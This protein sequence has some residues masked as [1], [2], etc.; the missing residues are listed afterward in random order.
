MII[1]RNSIMYAT[2]CKLRHPDLE[3]VAPTA[4][5]ATGVILLMCLAGVSAA[6]AMNAM[7]LSSYGV[8]LGV[9]PPV[10]GL[11]VGAICVYCWYH[12]DP[13]YPHSWEDTP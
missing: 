10:I 4:D 8:A 2:Y 11:Y 6:V 13:W 3:L 9:L 7:G 12:N 5:F 1:E